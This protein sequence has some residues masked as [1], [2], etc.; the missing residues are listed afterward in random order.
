[1]SGG[2]NC[3]LFQAAK[4]VLKRAP[5]LSDQQVLA[6]RGQPERLLAWGDGPGTPLYTVAQARRDVEAGDRA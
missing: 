6:A 2:P 3:E 5:E 1:M 4:K